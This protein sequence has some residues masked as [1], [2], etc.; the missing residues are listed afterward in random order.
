MIIYPQNATE[1]Q[2]DILA[3]EKA[4]GEY[5]ENKTGE[6]RIFPVMLG[7]REIE[8]RSEDTHKRR[9][10]QDSNSHVDHDAGTKFM[11]GDLPEAG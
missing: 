3:E 4:V 6:D 2:Q 11:R 7:Q 9:Q 10:H 8:H 1:L 5:T